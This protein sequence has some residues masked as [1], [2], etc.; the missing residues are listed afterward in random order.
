MEYYKLIVPWAQFWA[1]NSCM[2]LNIASGSPGEGGVLFSTK[3]WLPWQEQFHQTPTG[4]AQVPTVLWSVPHSAWE[5]QCDQES[6]K[7]K[8]WLH[9][10]QTLLKYASCPMKQLINRLIVSKGTWVKLVSTASCGTTIR[11]NEIKHTVQN[12]WCI[13]RYKAKQRSVLP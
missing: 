12:Q 4:R 13:W 8:A 1:S 3:T 11:C 10:D 9:G 2:L 7:F 5:H 6:I